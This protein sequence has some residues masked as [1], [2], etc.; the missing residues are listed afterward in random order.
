V[1]LKTE[2]RMSSA[3]AAGGVILA[4]FALIMLLPYVWM[5][6]NSVKP[7]AEIMK[8]NTFLPA[9][10]TAANYKK[11]FDT[12]PIAK[13]MR[14]SVFVTT[15]GTFIVLFSST[16]I[17]FVFAKYRFWGKTALFWLLLAMMMVPSQ[18]TL[19]PS[20]ILINRI[21]L[22]DKLAALVVPG[23]VSGF[24]IFLMRQFIE[25][26]PDSLCEAA[27]IDGA[28]D[29]YIYA[30][31]ILP[32]IRPAIGALAIFTFLGYWNEYLAPLLYLAKPENMTMP[33]AL[34]FFSDQHSNDVGA[35]MAA[36]TIV[37]TPVT[38][39]FLAFQKQFIK[40]IAITG[41]K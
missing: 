16:L 39:F 7:R 27:R 41:I 25:D 2:R 17:G 31:V 10:W 40:G 11:V 18:T 34:S 38:V 28:R 22:Y 9:A 23:M 1:E 29:M 3:M 35:I 24:G 26:V 5:L 12:A 33:L 13:W 4:V 20:F 6:L 32:L 15:S 21:G 37:M 30:R 19:I 14:N 8:A 36:A